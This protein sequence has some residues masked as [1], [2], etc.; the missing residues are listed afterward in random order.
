M[1]ECEWDHVKLVVE[2]G[3]LAVR[4]DHPLLEVVNAYA[5][6]ETPQESRL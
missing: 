3:C 2:D 6:H 5:S 1:E 4:R